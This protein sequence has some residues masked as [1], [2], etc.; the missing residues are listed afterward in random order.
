[1]GTADTEGKI[2]PL[3]ILQYT[4][5]SHIQGTTELCPNHFL[6]TPAELTAVPCCNTCLDQVS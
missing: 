4:T 2:H 1:M 3:L 5:Q 6:W